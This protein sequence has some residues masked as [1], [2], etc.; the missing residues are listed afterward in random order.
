[1]PRLAETPWR[2]WYQSRAAYVPLLAALH[3]HLQVPRE[4]LVKHAA[5]VAGYPSLTGKPGQDEVAAS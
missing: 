5:A 3:W 4:M 1:M 2:A